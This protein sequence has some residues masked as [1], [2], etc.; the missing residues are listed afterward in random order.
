MPQ[1]QN[2]CT[3]RM[4]TWLELQT[5]LKMILA[6]LSTVSLLFQSTKFP[7]QKYIPY[8]LKK[9]RQDFPGGA[10]VNNPPANEGDMGLSPGPGRSHMP[11]SN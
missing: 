11:W 2:G 1:D 6:V 4:N 5:K 3:Y 9:Q 7:Y 10:V 8:I